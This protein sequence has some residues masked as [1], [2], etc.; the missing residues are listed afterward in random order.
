M[1]IAILVLPLQGSLLATNRKC[2]VIAG[3]R[4]SLLSLFIAMLLSLV[5]FYEVGLN[6]AAVSINQGNW[7]N[8]N[9][10]NVSWEFIFDSLTVSMLMPV[11]IISTCVQMYSLEY[12]KEDP[13]LPRFFS[14]LSLFTFV[15]LLLITGD[16]LFIMFMGWEGVGVVS[17]LLVNYWYTSTANNL[18]AMKA[19]FMNKIGDWGFIQAIVLAMGIYMDISLA[20]IFSLSHH[21]NPDLLLFFILSIILAASAKS[22]QISLHTWLAAAMAGPTPVSSL[23]HSSTMVTAGIYLLMR[24]SPILELSSTALMIVVWLGSLTALLGA[25]CGLVENDIKKIIAFSTS[26]Q[27]GYMI[28]ACGISQYSLALFHLINHAFFKSLLFLSA[29]AFIHAVIDQQ[30]IR[31]M[32]SLNLLTPISYSV[33]LLGSLSL[34]AFPFMTGFYS[35][36]FLLEILLVPL[37]ISH[38]IAYVLTLL[39]ALLTTI[40]SVRLLAYAMLS[41][42]QFPLSLLPFVKDSPFLMTFPMLF[43]SIGAVIQGYMTQELFQAYGSTFYGQSLFTHPDHI[44]LLD[45]PFAESSLALIP[46]SFL[47]LAF[48]AIP[49]QSK[50]NFTHATP[51][52]PIVSMDIKESKVINSWRYSNIF[53]PY[54]MNHFNIF[55]HW[56]MHRVLVLSVLIYRYWDKGIIEL[57]GPV[58][59]AR[60]VNR[61]GFQIELL[62]TGFIPHQGFIIITL[63]LIFI[64]QPIYMI[65]FVVLCLQILQI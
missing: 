11:M 22:A 24:F 35:K 41:R 27:L 56:I 13:H 17:Y 20:T 36:D 47:L 48:L 16:N 62:A 55:N 64:L 7:V 6:G 37:N 63:M 46:L 8:N 39:A 9:N 44:R 33:F 28:V 4:L 12:L 57:L 5:A 65:S 31:K 29:G 58:G 52:T 32:G 43:I 61:L 51:L 18:A 3:P 25:A 1:Y 30:D 40:Y 49:F 53:D 42:P 26:S 50:N 60:W 14:Y 15:M 45:A 2:G 23:L 21:M 38:T 59:C 10:I 54:V 19:Q 34:M